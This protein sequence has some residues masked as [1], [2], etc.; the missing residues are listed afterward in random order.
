MAECLASRLRERWFFDIYIQKV[1]YNFK[2]S[3][4]FSEESSS[5]HKKISEAARAVRI[6]LIKLLRAHDG[7]LGANRR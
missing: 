7:C 6:R 4:E 3:L 5:Y 2:L 1:K